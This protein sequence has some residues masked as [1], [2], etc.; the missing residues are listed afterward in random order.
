MI[1]N[2]TLLML[3]LV[4][5]PIG[6]MAL[7]N[8]AEMLR[9]RQLE[10]LNTDSTDVFMDVSERLKTILEEEGEE[11]LFYKTW[12]RQIS[13]VLDNVSSSQALAMIGEIR[14]YA[15]DKGSKYGFFI[16]S[17]LNA[18]VAKDMGMTDRAEE[19]LLEAIDYQERYLSKKKPMTQV[20]YHLARIYEEK[21]QGEKAV[22]LI[23]G[24]HRR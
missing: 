9:Q 22:Q 20:Y 23:D 8:Q 18:H 14:D 4:G 5:F 6:I 15:E 17:I 1:K 10:L 16:V 19:L 2:L 13:F 7:S 12:Y 3:F 11:D 24:E 21:H